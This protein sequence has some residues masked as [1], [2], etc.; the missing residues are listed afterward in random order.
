MQGD[1]TVTPVQPDFRVLFE[2]APGLFL[3]LRPELTIVAASDAYLRASMT[4]REAIVGR[5]IFEVFPDNPADQAANGVANLRASLQHVIATRMAHVMPIQKYDIRRPESEGGGFEERYW[6]PVNSPVVAA[7]GSLSFIIHRVEDVTQAHLGARQLAA[8]NWELAQAQEELQASQRFLDSIVEEMPNMLFV[9]EATTLKFVRFNKAGERLLGLSRE[10]LIGRSDRDLFPADE[11]EAFISKDREVLKGQHVVH[12]AEE[13]IHTPAGVRYL[14]THKVPILDEHGRARYLLGVSE[15]I[16]EEKRAAGELARARDEAED[17]S[18]A[19]SEFLA[20]MSHELRTPLNSIIGFS[21]VLADGTFGALNDKQQRY[22]GNVITSGRHLL[23]LINDILDLS[24]V[25]ARRMDLVKTPVSAAT[26]VTQ[27]QTLLAPLADEKDISLTSRV[28]DG[29]PTLFADDARLR[30][31]LGNLV[32]N[33]IKYTRA[34]GRVTITARAVTGADGAPWIELAVEDNGIGI[35]AEDQERIFGEFEQVASSYV[36]AQQGTGLGLALTRRLAALH[37][38]TLSVE[39]TLGTGSTFRLLLPAGDG[40]HAS[41]PSLPGAHAATGSG[42]L[43]LVIDD[44]PTAAD[45]IS[46]YLTQSGYRVALASDSDA[47]VALARQLQ[48]EAIT[49]DILLPG[50]GGLSVLARLKADASTRHI[51]VIVV[52]ITEDR[53]VGYSLGAAEWF[54][55]PVSREDLLASVRRVLLPGMSGKALVIDDDPTSVELIGGYLRSARFTVSTATNGRDGIARALADRPDVI[56]LDLLMPEMNGFDVVD[57]LRDDPSGRDIPILIVTAK[58]I[59]ESERLRL[60]GSVQ[61]IVRKGDVR[62]RLLGELR[63][64]TKLSA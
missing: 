7:D 10:A 64:A 14:R 15:D 11:A 62:S 8:M 55:K 25:E 34:G 42:P 59:T 27:V 57:A 51:P 13:P 49:L 12:I 19:K 37:G 20:R 1:R 60:R 54:V 58:D 6:S 63:R 41:V 39:S 45:L 36:R 46:H 48:P 35:G 21:E 29:L 30:Q 61:G 2:N 33:A 5:N 31:M 9:K 43:V 26:M 56:V 38:G 16:T 52:S 40:A 3:V 50:R 4:A 23:E 17:S 44:E 32:G 47:A 22:V 28:D 24:K 18:R 53:S